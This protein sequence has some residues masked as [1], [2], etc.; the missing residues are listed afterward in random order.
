MG[1]VLLDAELDAPAGRTSGVGVGGAAGEYLVGT[2]D[3]FIPDPAVEEG[4]VQ[5]GLVVAPLQTQFAIPRDAG[6]E[7]R[8]H[9]GTVFPIGQLLKGRRLEPLTQCR[10]QAQLRGPVPVQADR[11]VGPLT[12]GVAAVILTVG[13]KVIDR[14]STRLNSSHVR[15]SYAV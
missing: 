6:L 13:Q 8:V 10:V 14:K 15:I 5:P 3:D 7:G 12:A 1:E 2:G 4:E 11:R 9:A